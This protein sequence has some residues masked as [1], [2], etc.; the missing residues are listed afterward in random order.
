MAVQL[1]RASIHHARYAHYA[2]RWKL[3]RDILGGKEDIDAAGELYLPRP[4]GRDDLEYR[5]YQRR[6]VLYNATA[7]TL[8][9]YLGAIFRKDIDITLPPQLSYMVED[10]DGGGNNITQFCK[11]VTK[12][13][14]SHGRYGLLV[15]YPVAENVR[16]AAEERQLNLRPHI[17]GYCPESI[18]N[19]A[20]ARRG[21]RT[22]LVSVLIEELIDN[23]ANDG[24]IFDRNEVVRFRNLELDSD[25]YY[26]IRILEE[27]VVVDPKTKEE[28]NKLVEVQTIKPR[29]PGGKR[30]DFIPFVF[31]GSVDSTPDPDEPPLYDLAQLNLAHY[32]NSADLED[33]A[34]M[35]GQPTTYITGLDRTFIEENQGMMRFGSRVT[36]LLPPNSEVGMVESKSE[37]N[38]ILKLLEKK[39]EEMI[40]I[41]ARIVA[42]NTARGSE[43]AESVR[44]RRSGE[45]SL[46][47]CIADNVS[48]AMI[49]VFN[50]AAAWMGN[51]SPE[52]RFAL[53]TDFFSA[54]LTANE[55]TSLVGAWQSGAISQNVML[56]NFRKGELIS[57]T[58]T[59][60]DVLDQLS[61]EGPALT[62]LNDTYEPL[63]NTYDGGIDVGED[64]QTNT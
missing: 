36:W 53:N 20:I 27:Q 56:D 43:S 47:A 32:R 58:T 35:I 45:A 39:E 34:Y 40:G 48:T 59:N 19:W 30:L 6:A 26:V 54:R 18:V 55:I 25:G 7:R 15:D 14:I 51:S 9:G 23:S 41:G 4:Q 3:I 11:R 52:I 12:D 8:D 64:R 42:D 31:V 61:E 37:K 60:E 29:L 13:T 22:V 17:Q 62:L 63:N 2:S 33:A 50:W 44:L 46:L 16:T 28:E 21:A 1:S 49:K 5:A 38:L 57:A 10:T 24:H